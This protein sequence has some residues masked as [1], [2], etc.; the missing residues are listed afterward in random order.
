[1]VKADDSIKTREITVPGENIKDTGG[2][3]GV[4]YSWEKD[5][6]VVTIMGPIDA[7]SKISPEDITIKLDMSPYDGSNT[8]GIRVRAE[9]DI[10]SQY[11]DQVIEVGYYNVLVTI[12]E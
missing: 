10:D 8:G 1:M 6:I 2:K 5:P 4:Q 9:I 12:Y 11:A 7:I 3:T